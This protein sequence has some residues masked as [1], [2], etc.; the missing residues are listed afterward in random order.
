MVSI[1]ALNDD[2]SRYWTHLPCG[3]VDQS[4]Q[5]YTHHGEIAPAVAGRVASRRCTLRVSLE[6]VA[7]DIPHGQAAD[8]GSPDESAASTNLLH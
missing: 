8:K 3:A 5:I 4:I 7:A 6:Y 1:C 2:T